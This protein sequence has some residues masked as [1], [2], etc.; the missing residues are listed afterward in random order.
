MAE[1][2]TKFV[3][4]WLK[5]TT[6]QQQMSTEVISDHKNTSMTDNFSPPL[7]ISFEIALVVMMVSGTIGN[8][9]VITAICKTKKLRIWP[10]ALLVNM[11][12][13]DLGVCIMVIPTMLRRNLP[14][15][16]PHV[17][18]FWC[19][20]A[21]YLNIIFCGVSLGT[22]YCISFTRYVLITKPKHVYL[23]FCTQTGTILI[24]V[25]VW[26]STTS[27][28]FLPLLGFGT[29]EYFYALNGCHIKEDDSLSWWYMTLLLLLGVL[30][31]VVIIPSAYILIFIRIHK[32]RKRV[33]DTKEYSHQGSDGGRNRISKRREQYLSK[34]EL[35]VTRMMVIACVAFTI[36][37]L[38]F[39]L[40]HL[41]S[42][43]SLKGPLASR[44]ASLFAVAHSVCNPI[45]YAGMNP[46]F[47]EAFRNVLS[48]K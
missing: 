34:E 15:A 33:Q 36:C 42:Y 7:L 32:S 3:P 20:T 26:T 13:A 47:R 31:C 27:L 46:I 38:P 21:F 11:A 44:V 16:V 45:I 10:N 41:L 48:C 25:W 43:S 4:E 2:A 17:S 28:T 5:L 18:L 30:S 40:N 24:L 12:L 6:Q 8:V 9:L 35:A 22:L 29:I 37:W 19:R 23:K 1:N 39:T 14:N